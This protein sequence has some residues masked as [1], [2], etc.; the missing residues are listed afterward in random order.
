MAQ[1][2]VLIPKSKYE[3]LLPNGPPPT[4]SQVV[5]VTRPPVG[6]PAGDDLARDGQTVSRE[7]A[8]SKLQQSHG[9][10]HDNK[11]YVSDSA[12]SDSEEESVADVVKGDAT[13]SSA[14]QSL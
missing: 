13:W 8:T 6:L 10:G 14:W 2:Y 1:E 3:Q 7:E 5:E 12:S 11:S 4:P 9:K